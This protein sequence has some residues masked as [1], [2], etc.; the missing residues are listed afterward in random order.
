[1]LF[2]VHKYSFSDIYAGSGFQMRAD[3]GLMG[4]GMICVS[5]RVVFLTAREVR[6]L[7]RVM[8][9]FLHDDDD[10]DEVEGDG[11]GHDDAETELKKDG[12]ASSNKHKRSYRLATK[13]P[14]S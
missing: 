1:M 8:Q 9:E 5:I 6:V 7:S 11:D 3:K 14:V 13:S 2:L 4:G 12:T 10:D